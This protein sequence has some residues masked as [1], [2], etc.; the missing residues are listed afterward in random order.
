METKNIDNTVEISQTADSQLGAEEQRIRKLSMSSSAESDNETQ[1]SLRTLSTGGPVLSVHTIEKVLDPTPKSDGNNQAPRSISNTIDSLRGVAY[2]TNVDRCH[3][4]FQDFRLAV[5]D[6]LTTFGLEEREDEQLRS[7]DPC[8]LRL[9]Q[10]IETLLIHGILNLPNR[11]ENALLWRFL[12][13][14]SNDL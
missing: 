14:H 5:E 4:L 3:E 10:T 9:V 11:K 12:E 13:L 7:W 1:E 2:T 8:V 6:C